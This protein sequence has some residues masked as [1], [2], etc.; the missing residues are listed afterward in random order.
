MFTGVTHM[1]WFL[2]PD[3]RIAISEVAARPP[4]AQFSTLISYAHEFDL[5]RAW[6]RLLVFEQFDRPERKFA[7]GA[8][9][10]RGQGEG[11]IVALEGLEECQREIGG[12]VVEAKLP[13]LGATPSSS[14]EGD[15]YVIVRH[16]ETEVV[17]TALQR[18]VNTVRVK[19]G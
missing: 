18:I 11:K 14:Y 12:L 1:E 15:G 19:L 2:R 5:Y 8:A 13:T 9:Y 3:G 10:L 16:R 6:A 17:Q 7:C 4:G